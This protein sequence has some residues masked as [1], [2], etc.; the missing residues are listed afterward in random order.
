[1]NRFAE[2]LD[3]LVLTP[4]RNGK[5]TLL[6]DYFRSVEDPDRGLA[7]A[8]ITGDLNIAA[9]KPAMLRTL[10]TERMDPVL[11]GYSYD[12]VGDLAETV[13]LVWP[14]TPGTIPNREPT[15]GEVV[16]KLQAA[17]RSDGPKVL[18]NLLDSAGISARFAI[19]KLVTGGLR[20]GVSARLAKQALA[21]FGK[22]DVAEIEE[23]WHGLSPPYTALFAWLEGKAAKP[24]RAARALFRPVM[25]S[26]P[27]GD[28]DLDRL[29]PADYVAEW[30]WDGIRVQAVSE[31]GIRRLYSRTGDD[32]SGAF[33]DLAEAMVFSAT[34]DGEL[35]VG[36]PREATGTFSDLQQRL[37][38]KTVSLKMQQQ[39]PAFMRCYDLLQVGAEDL[40]GLPF[41]ERRV[42]LENFVKTLDPSRFD[43][44]PFVAFSDWQALEEL[45]RAPPHPIIEGVMLKRWDSPYVAGRPKGPWFKW[46]RDPH[47][48]D[49]VLMYAQR[50]HGKRSSFYSDYT[51]GVWSGAEGEE[52]L[53]PVGKAY[54]GF[55]DEEL[56]QIDKYVRDNT[57][58]RFGPVRSVRADRDNGLVLEVAFEGLNRSTR[59]KSGVAM[60]FPRISRLRWDKPANE[61]DRIETLQALLDR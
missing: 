7:L 38:R 24:E 61:A 26:N 33:P 6:T 30:K 52:E 50:G 31:G 51:F 44:S 4:S 22:V 11:F 36:D 32:V 14:Q 8:A 54:F 28:G 16:A 49:A 47:T 15:L 9:I 56:R 41:R 48:V 10:V 23:L 34:L 43:L 45:R 46:K 25:L 40:R 39:Y 12:Y 2:L 1:M 17:S 5:L 35:L 60:R 42:R 37:N 57:I 19:I 55:T 3:R 58:E 13:S 27:V 53:V 20:I 29:D 18:S 21:D 59:H